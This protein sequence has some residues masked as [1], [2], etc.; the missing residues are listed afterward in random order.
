M[1]AGGDERVKHRDPDPGDLGDGQRAIVPH[2]LEQGAGWYELHHDPGQAV[3]EDDVEDRDDV[4]V[5][6][7]FGGVPRL[8]HCALYPVRPLGARDATGELDF[9]E[10]GLGFQDGIEGAPDG[11]HRTRT[12][13]RDESISARHHAVAFRNGSHDTPLASSI[14]AGQHPR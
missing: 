1:V 13:T 11:A 6:A 12:Q 3:L 9:L 7:K 5:A 10:R 14:V 8:A 2:D 4:R